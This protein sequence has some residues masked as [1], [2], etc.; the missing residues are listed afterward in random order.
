MTRIVD[1]HLRQERESAGRRDEATERITEIYDTRQRSDSATGLP[2]LLSRTTE[3]SLATSLSTSRERSEATTHGYE[4]ESRM[5][6]ATQTREA[7]TATESARHETADS[8]SREE[9]GVKWWL[10]GLAYLGAFVL[11]GILIWVVCIIWRIIKLFS[12][13]R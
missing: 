2:P 12:N 6:E 8:D 10:T 3:R 4:S 1:E 9:R 5:T 7:D 11:L 13:N